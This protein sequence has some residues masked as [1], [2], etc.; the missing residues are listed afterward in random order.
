VSPEEPKT[1]TTD[2]DPEKATTD[3]ENPKGIE[4]KN[5]NP[6]SAPVTTERNH[7]DPSLIESF[8]M[9]LRNPHRDKPKW[10]DVA[11]V[12][13]TLGIVFL[14]YM[15]Y[16]EMHGSGV[17]TH[18]LAVQAKAQA[19]AARASA[20]STKTLGDRMKDQAGRTKTIAEQA[21]IQ[22]NAA[23]EA[24]KVARD[25]LVAS[26][27]PWA[28]VAYFTL[29][30]EPESG[31]PAPTIIFLPANSGKAPGL[32]VAVFNETFTAPAEGEVPI[33]AFKVQAP[34]STIMLPPTTLPVYGAPMGVFVSTDV[35]NSVMQPDNL[36]AYRLGKN[37]IYVDV[38]IEYSDALHN[39]YWTTV[40]VYHTHNV[41]T[42]VFT[43]C[44]TGNEVG[45]YSRSDTEH[46]QKPN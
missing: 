38:K 24:N 31:K 41:A 6:T 11:I 21:V 3:A 28:Y 46:R 14:G 39:R 8:K 40:C 44:K 9:W 37:V 43:I 19:D 18:D 36:A 30:A 29:T 34:P 45:T 22:A 20:D 25:S 5:E 10:T 42:N 7:P 15:Q 26:E 2:S 35:I 23:L 1:T 13:L 16:K 17:D 12:F 27:R 33:S 4:A 32:D